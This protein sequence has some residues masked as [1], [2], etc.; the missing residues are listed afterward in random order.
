MAPSYRDR[1]TCR[2]CDG[3]SLKRAVHL[4]PTPIADAFVPPSRADTTQDVYPLGLSLCTACGHLQ[5]PHV[6]D[7]DVLFRDYI[8]ATD[9]SV[10]LVEHFVLLARLLLERSGAA[11]RALAVDIGSNDGSMLAAFRDV[12]LTPVG[13]DPARE[14]AKRASA[15]GLPTLPDYFGADLATRIRDEH[16]AAAIVTA[17]N[18][19]AHSDSLGDMADGVR[20]LLAR[21]GLFEFEVNYA[22]DILENFLFD[23]VYHEHLCYHAVEP[24]KHFLDRHDLALVDVER[25]QSKGG[26]IRCFA[27]RKDGPLPESPSVASLIDLERDLGVGRLE[28]YRNFQ[29]R[30]EACATAV[31]S[32][33]GKLRAQ[34]RRIAAYG[35]SP[36]GTTLEYHFGL[37]E[38]IDVIYDDNSRKHGLQSPGHHIPVKP[39][40]AL[41]QDRPDCIVILAWR[42][43]DPI[44][45]RHARYLESG[46]R[47]FVPCPSPRFVVAPAISAEP[48]SSTQRTGTP[49]R[50]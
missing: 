19:F 4:T 9:T 5:L 11:S 39:S 7:P 13:V 28:T 10:G 14:L 38:F 1:E 50:I 18:V 37:H 45:R 47:F 33:L 26:S 46:G 6:V 17:N 48:I 16:G 40:E 27:Q 44:V 3:R 49:P 42:Y 21:D 22:V 31:R 29:D 35:A 32:E 30:I 2:L 43:A 25:N 41:Y 20:I 15:A 23:T 24:L 8:Y 36:T 12:G 34:G